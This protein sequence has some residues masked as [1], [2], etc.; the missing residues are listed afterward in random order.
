MIKGISQNILCD[1]CRTVLNNNYYLIVPAG[2]KLKHYCYNHKCFDIDKYIQ[3]RGYK[4]LSD[5][6]WNE[7]CDAVE[8]GNRTDEAPTC[9]EFYD[10]IVF[11]KKFNENITLEIAKATGLKND[12]YES[13][14]E[15][16][17]C[18]CEYK[19][20]FVF[21]D[22]KNCQIIRRIFWEL[23][24][25]RHLISFIEQCEREASIIVDRFISR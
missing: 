13:I 21:F 17:G 16:Y 14:A 5:Q 8:F 25:K 2:G 9:N 24:D 23:G 19:I 3:K 15:C 4:K 11:R 10:K 18:F 7:R 20:G 22:P 1:K 6:T 12:R